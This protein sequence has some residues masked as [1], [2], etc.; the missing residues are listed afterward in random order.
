MY[1]EMDG[2]LNQPFWFDQ[3]SRK[4]HDSVVALVPAQ[5]QNVSNYRTVIRW[6]KLSSLCEPGTF[7]SYMEPLI[8]ELFSRT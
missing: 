2:C 6:Q 1:L 8:N 4:H 5:W 3:I 7:V